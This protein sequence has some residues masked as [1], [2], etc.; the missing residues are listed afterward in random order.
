MFTFHN[1]DGGWYLRL[2][3]DAMAAERMAV[4]KNG[5]SYTFYIWDEQN[6]SAAPLFTVYSFTGKDREQLATDSNRFPLYRGEN[7]VYAGKLEVG[8]GIYGITQESLTKDFCLIG[9]DWKQEG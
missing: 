7:V 6:E 3:L 4:E 1:V 8:S 5:S 9:V 2:D